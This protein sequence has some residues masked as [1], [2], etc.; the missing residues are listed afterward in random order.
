MLLI[1]FISSCDSPVRI[2]AQKIICTEILTLP[3]HTNNQPQ[4]RTTLEVNQQL[5][6]HEMFEQ[7]E[8]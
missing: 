6:T 4:Q 2:Q 7:L 5:Y 8:N 1:S 3:S